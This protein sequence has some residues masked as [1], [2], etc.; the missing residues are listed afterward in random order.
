MHCCTEKRPA[1]LARQADRSSD[2]TSASLAVISAS[3]VHR[4]PFRPC[5][6]I[7][8]AAPSANVR[9]EELDRMADRH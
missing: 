9:G 3:S 6:T 7:S 2:P 4:K 8:G 1:T 5:S